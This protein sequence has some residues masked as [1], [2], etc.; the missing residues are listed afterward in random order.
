[1]RSPGRLP[2]P[3]L[4]V[5]RETGTLTRCAV[6]LRVRRSCV[7]STSSRHPP[8]CLH[9]Y[10]LLRARGRALRDSRE[11]RVPLSQTRAARAV[12]PLAA[13]LRCLAACT[14]ELL[15]NAKEKEK[16]KRKGSYRIHCT[17]ICVRA[18]TLFLRQLPPRAWLCYDLLYTLVR[19]RF[20][21]SFLSLI[22]VN[23]I[24]VGLRRRCPRTR[25]ITAPSQ[26]SLCLLI[27]DTSSP[28]HI[29]YPRRPPPFSLS[30][31]LS[32]SLSLSSIRSNTLP[33]FSLYT[34]SM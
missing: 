5:A 3:A 22:C 2:H 10:P 31:S 28:S 25:F 34:I 24:C 30:L 1:M 11:C 27:L 16:R 13:L 4:R 18:W 21:L 26:P 29:P 23:S 6:C 8:R 20:F 32:F 12:V 9:R 14:S 17:S 7:S 15:P 33:K 19:P